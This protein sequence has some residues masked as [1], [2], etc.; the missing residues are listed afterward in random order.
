MGQWG[1]TQTVITDWSV[2][3]RGPASVTEDQEKDL[4]RSDDKA[5]S[6]VELI[7]SYQ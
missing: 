7:K 5:E 3:W 6:L 1:S 2:P 4:E